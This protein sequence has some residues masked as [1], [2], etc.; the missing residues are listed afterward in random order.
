MKNKNLYQ[1]HLQLQD[2]ESNILFHLFKSRINDFYKHNGIRIQ[3]I[4]DKLTSLQK[5]Y[6]VLEDGKVKMSD[7]ETNESGAEEPI[8]NEG[9]TFEEYMEK[10]TELMETNCTIIF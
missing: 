7:S 5:E 6:F 9:K 3:T 10:Y 1:F 4:C 2:L 8:T